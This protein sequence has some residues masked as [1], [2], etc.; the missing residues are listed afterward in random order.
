MGA[1]TFTQPGD[2]TGIG[3]LGRERFSAHLFALFPSRSGTE[4]GA[5]LLW[6]SA[7]VSERAVDPAIKQ[8]FVGAS[9]SG[10]LHIETI[11]TIS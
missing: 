3:R 10:D 4:L 11:E 7:I 1:G 8:T 9:S 5:L 6:H 2:A